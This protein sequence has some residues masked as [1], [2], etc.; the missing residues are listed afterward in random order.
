MAIKN[1][2][3]TSEWFIEARICVADE[4]VF[5]QDQISH[6]QEM[7]DNIED[8]VSTAIRNAKRN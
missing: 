8:G 3:I 2:N 6:L 7:I 1:P 4:G 5:T